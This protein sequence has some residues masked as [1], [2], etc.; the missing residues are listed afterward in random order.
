[1]KTRAGADGH[2]FEDREYVIDRA[3]DADAQGIFYRI[4]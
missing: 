3:V 2:E 1:M 4:R